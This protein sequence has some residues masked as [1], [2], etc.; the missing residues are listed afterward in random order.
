ME[1]SEM[2]D[3]EYATRIATMLVASFPNQPHDPATFLRQLTIVCTGRP[4]S[5]LRKLVDPRD[6]FLTT[7]RFPT[8]AALHDWLDKQA[9]WEPTQAF[10]RKQIEQ[11]L[12]DRRADPPMTQEERDR[13]DDLWQRV[14]CEMLE[15]AKASGGPAPNFASTQRHDPKNLLQAMGNLSAMRREGNAP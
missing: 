14:K 5:T 8:I 10:R 13:C 6:G 3:T 15:R 2:A 9:A 7:E 1:N 12:E 11:Q 4:K